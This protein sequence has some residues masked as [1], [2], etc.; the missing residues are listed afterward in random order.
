MRVNELLRILNDTIQ[1]PP[2]KDKIYTYYAL[3]SGSGR[4]VF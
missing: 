3:G 2:Q 4:A 1:T